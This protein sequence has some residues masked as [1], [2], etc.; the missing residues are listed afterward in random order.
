[1]SGIN[2]LYIV[3]LGICIVLS[4]F[5]SGSETALV[6]IQRER[7]H[8][9]AE[10]S[11]R[12]AKLQDLLSNPDRTLSTLL[13]ANNFVN[14][15]AAAVATALLIDLAG[16]SWGPWIVTLALT[17]VILVFGEIGPKTLANRYP[18][19]FS[20]LV[21]GPITTLVTV[22][23]PI[24]RSFIIIT[25][26]IFKLFGLDLGTGI[27]PVTEDDIRALAFISES[28]GEIK[29]AERE[30]IDALFSLED[31][32]IREV[33]T[34]RVGMI[35]IPIP[36]TAE[37]I[38]EAVATSGHSR[39]PVVAD[40]TD[41]ILGI[42]A[43]KDVLRLKTAATP[44]DINRILRPPTYI[45]ESRPVLDVLQEM[46][47]SRFG[48]GVVVDEHGG[49]EGVV[50]TKDV[51][52][53]L[54]GELQDE[55]DPSIPM[56]TPAGPDRW[57]IDGRVDVDELEAVLEME[58]PR[59]DYSTVAGLF[60]DEAG[61]IP[62]EGDAIVLDGISMTVLMMDRRRIARLRVEK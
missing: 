36:V 16:E 7:A 45:P 11:Q 62:E 40:S 38:E 8:Q 21:A 57:I 43:V 22:L 34:P 1:V 55:Y 29:A 59:G 35:S 15:L 42:L 31:R 56:L 50:T 24:S 19:R 47:K 5:F 52:A 28:T 58:L 46:R 23:K 4:G 60:M 12:G 44:E 51:I 32:P 2:I 53:E 33:M 14:I 49:V 37:K 13:V 41:E 48:F 6:S 27:A 54:V 26:G 39:F 3:V 10:K 30:I 17:A 9:L 20:L 25:R 61:R 18:E